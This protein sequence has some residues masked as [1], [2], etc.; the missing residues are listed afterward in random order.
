MRARLLAAFAAVYILWGSTYL[1]IRF[2]VETLPPLAMAA[3]RFVTAGIILLLWAR[4]RGEERGPSRADWR[5]GLISGSLLLVGGNGL[6]VWAEQRVPSG[7][8]ALLVAVVPLW[9]VLLDWLRP[10]GKR[11]PVLVF[12]GLALGLLGLGLLVGT[13]ALHGQGNVDVIGAV[14]LMIASLSWAAG[15]LYT[16]HMPRSSSGLH[17]AATQMVCGGVCLGILSL[18]A[19]EASH[20]DLA[21]A[22][23]QSV[24]GLVY[25]ITFGSLVGYTA[26]VYLLGHTTAAKAATYAYVNPVVAVFLGWAIAHEP[27]TV[28]TVVAAI[29]ILAG[30]AIITVSNDRA[31]SLSESERV[32]A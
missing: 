20:L 14:M 25:L 1:A 15:S 28:R 11:P 10:E 24:T 17:A 16:K 19:G 29:V 8:T 23:W 4:L 31:V 32:A 7:I 18:F 2:A 21:R 13:D 3:T 9:M 5:A 12:V 26:Y 22:S 30:V 27:V 6:V